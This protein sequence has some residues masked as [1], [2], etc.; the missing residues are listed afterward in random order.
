MLCRD[1]APPSFDDGFVITEVFGLRKLVRIGFRALK[2]LLVLALCVE[3][4]SFIAVTAINYVLYGNPREGIAVTT[5]DAYTVFRDARGPRPTKNNALSPDPKL[6]KTIWMFGGST[7]RGR[8]PDDGK[9]IPSILSGILNAEMKP[10]HFTALNFGMD[11]FNSLL[12]TKYLQKVMIENSTRPDLIIFYDGANDCT[13]LSIHRDPYGH[14]GMRRLKAL[15]ESY[16]N[17]FFGLFKQFNAAVRASFTGELYNKL[18][19]GVEPMKEDSPLLTEYVKAAV[20][21][22]E[23]VNKV[24]SCYGAKFIIFQQPL[25]WSE[26]CRIAESVREKEK[27]LVVSYKNFDVLQRNFGMPY[28]AM[29]NQLKDKPYFVN[30]RDI[31]CGRTV[32]VY[33]ADGVH[34]LDEGREMVARQMADVIKQKLG[35]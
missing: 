32:P 5:Y 6:N 15:I 26:E 29:V 22:Y 16:H 8:T 30:F 19:W 23:Y 21:R 7:M 12:E 18:L 20:A 9:T 24:A 3:A 17:S 1:A 11:S 28:N 35:D 33:Q 31:L 2:W 27:G 4:F 10:L 25:L 14:H 13:Y 34:L